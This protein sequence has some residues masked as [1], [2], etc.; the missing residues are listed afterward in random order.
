M[1][2]QGKKSNGKVVVKIDYLPSVNYSMVNSGMDICKKLVLENNDDKDWH[3]LS[4]EIKGQYIKPSS[5]FPISLISVGI[6]PKR[7][8]LVK[9][10]LITPAS[11]LNIQV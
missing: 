4:V 5:L 2:G 11:N 6:F 3:H 1:A 7:H 10:L 8:F 9:C